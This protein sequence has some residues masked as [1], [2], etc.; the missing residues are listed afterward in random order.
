MSNFDEKTGI[1]YGVISPHSINQDALNDIYQDGTDPQYE[2]GKE[3]FESGLKETIREYCDNNA[4]LDIAD[5]DIDIDSIME[6]WN[7]N[8]QSDGSG[9]MDYSDNEYDLHVSGDNFGIFV[10]ASPYYTYCR[11]CSPCAPGAGSLDSPI[12]KDTGE[13]PADPFL[14]RALCLGPEWFDKEESEYSRK[15]PYRV[16]RVDNDE[17]VI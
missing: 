4:N 11:D 12:D 14:Y 13:F 2:E 5:N 16:F 17:E 10:M 8:Y 7:D 9:I 6:Q 1:R 15:I 3:N